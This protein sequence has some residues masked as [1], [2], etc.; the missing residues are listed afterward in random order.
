MGYYRASLRPFPSE[1]KKQEEECAGGQGLSWK[2]EKQNEEIKV[3][4]EFI[5]QNLELSHTRILEI[6]PSLDFSEQTL[7]SLVH[8]HGVVSYS[9]PPLNLLANLAIA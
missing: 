8:H 6:I 7:F 9:M 1:R 3:V 4:E 2:G 5:I